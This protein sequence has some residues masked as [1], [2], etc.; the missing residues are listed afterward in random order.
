LR[1]ITDPA[2]SSGS[3]RTTYGYIPILEDYGI[4]YNGAGALNA[5][6]NTFKVAASGFSY[7]NLIA[8]NEVIFDKR[9]SDSAF[10]FAGR[11]ALTKIAQKVSDIAAPE[12]TWKGQVTLGTPQSNLALGFRQLELSTVHGTWQLV[13]TRSLRNQYNNY[14]V[15]PDQNNIGVA[16]FEPDLYKNNVKTDNDYDGVKDVIRTKKGLWMQLLKRHHMV[17]MT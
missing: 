15:I 11:G 6:T 9:E 4:T 8:Y 2:S 7:G 17:V 16:V 3:L 13:P 10:G 5:D 12:M 1:T 14:I